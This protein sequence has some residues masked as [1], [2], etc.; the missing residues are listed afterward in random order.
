MQCKKERIVGHAVT[1]P[2]DFQFQLI[3]FNL[4][5]SDPD[6]R[7]VTTGTLEEKMEKMSDPELRKPL[8]E[9][10]N[11]DHT[12]IGAMAN[13]IGPAEIWRR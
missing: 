13:N 4:F 12:F 2:T 10:F 6:W 1:V 11:P 5:D 7:A 9:K 3:D 8:K